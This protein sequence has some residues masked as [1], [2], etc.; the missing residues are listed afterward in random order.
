M[1]SCHATNLRAASAQWLV[2]P[3]GISYLYMHMCVPRWVL[4][5]GALYGVQNFQV[6]DS[7]DGNRT[8][9]VLNVTARQS[10]SRGHT[11]G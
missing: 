4:P 8:V 5:T 1:S 11:R 2:R 3:S 9:I 6:S 10:A 7:L